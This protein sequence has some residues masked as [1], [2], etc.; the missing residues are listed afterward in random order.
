MV[1]TGQKF[2]HKQHSIRSVSVL[3]KSL[4]VQD[5]RNY[6]F[7]L[8][9]TTPHQFPTVLLVCSHNLPTY[10]LH[11]LPPI[12]FTINLAVHLP[13]PLYI[14]SDILSTEGVGE[15]ADE[16]AMQGIDGRFHKCFFSSYFNQRFEK[17][18][19]NGSNLNGGPLKTLVGSASVWL[20]AKCQR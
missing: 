16:R 1:H 5:P 14:R 8:M 6:S 13:P 7:L 11:H 3:F 15:K 9:S 4:P 17:L 2:G 12:L 19:L 10:N 18:H 20:M